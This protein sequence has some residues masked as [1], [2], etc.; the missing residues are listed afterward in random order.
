MVCALRSSHS[1]V[2]ANC[3]SGRQPG[4]P[5]AS[6]TR[7]RASP[8]SRR[9]PGTA[10]TGRSTARVSASSV[11]GGRNMTA[12]P[13]G[14]EV[15][16]ADR[17]SV[18]ADRAVSTTRSPPPW[19]GSGAWA[20]ADRRR[21]ARSA[22]S[23]EAPA[24]SSNWSRSSTPPAAPSSRVSRPRSATRSSSLPAHACRTASKRVFQASPSG[25][26]SC[27]TAVTASAT[28]PSA[29]SAALP[30][31]D[32]GLGTRRAHGVPRSLTAV[33]R[34]ARSSEDF[35]LPEGPTR[36]VTG[37]DSSAPTRAVI[38]SSRPWKYRASSVSNR[39]RPRN[40]QRSRSGSVSRSAVTRYAVSAMTPLPRVTSMPTTTSSR[41]SHT[42]AP[43]NPGPMR[44]PSPSARRST[45][46]RSARWRPR[47]LPVAFTPRKAP[48]GKPNAR[49]SRSHS[50][51]SSPAR[52]SGSGRQDVTRARTRG[53]GRAPARSGKSTSTGSSGRFPSAV[54]TTWAQVQ[55][56]SSATRNPAP[57]GFP[58]GPNTRAAPRS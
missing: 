51:P 31:P 36:T 8:R 58:S 4:S 46:R 49:M 30:P 13:S 40:G 29:S 37:R 42:A 6:A 34:P 19:A 33:S 39:L 47:S 50:S 41:G 7:R 10:R 45:W 15:S 52:G 3:R 2:S 18:V 28:Q 54:A 48:T 5:T 53:P 35:P 16:A 20:S 21:K 17:T 23:G 11:M 14:A 9:R 56:R 27:Q 1:R 43:L 38:S 32:E 26:A 24:Y 44:T 22:P 12:S 57:A 55:S 25:A